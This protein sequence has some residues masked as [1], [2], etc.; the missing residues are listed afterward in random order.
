MD[1]PSEVSSS[2]SKPNKVDEIAALLARREVCLEQIFA[3]EKQKK[4]RDE[5]TAALY[6]DAVGKAPAELAEIDEKIGQIMSRHH[7]W[8]TRLYS[9]TLDLS[10]GVVKVTF[11]SIETVWPRNKR[12]LAVKLHHVFGEKYVKLVPELD[13]EAIARAPEED[14]KR[15]AP[16]GLKR[17]SHLTVLVKSPSET[18]FRTIFKRPYTPPKS[19][20]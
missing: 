17:M 19:S 18:K 13:V 10:T 3:A 4:D 11:R 1:S 2:E 7:H 15:M 6:E 9:Q 20:K 5:K 14:L 16:W 12:R 8:I